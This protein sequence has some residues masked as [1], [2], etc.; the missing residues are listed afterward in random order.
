MR[1]NALVAAIALTCGLLLPTAAQEPAPI[2]AKDVF[3]QLT[4]TIAWYQ[5]L[6]ATD[7]GSAPTA[8]N[9]LQRN[10]ARDFARQTM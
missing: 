8:E 10:N 9:L 6:L 1:K 2:A 3:Y 4:R 5:H 7:E